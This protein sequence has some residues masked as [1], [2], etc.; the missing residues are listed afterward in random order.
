MF[1]ADKNA[2]FSRLVEMLQFESTFEPAFSLVGA[3]LETNKNLIEEFLRVEPKVTDQIRAELAK[4]PQ[5]SFF[6][7]LTCPYLNEQVSIL[8]EKKKEPAATVGLIIQQIIRNLV[9]EI[10]IA[11]PAFQSSLSPNWTASGDIVLDS[12]LAER[13]PALKT[14]GGVSLNYQ[15]YAHNTGEPGIGG[16]S[17]QDAL[18]HKERIETAQAIVAKVSPSALSMVECFT[19]VIQFRQNTERPNVVNSSRHTSIGL[20][21]CD[22]FHK[23]HDDMPEV[24]DMLVHESIHQ[25]LHLFEEQLFAFVDV[26]KAPT[27][28][29]DERLYPSPWSGNLLDLRS[30]TH[31]ILV[32]YGLANFWEQF[33]LGRFEHPEVSNEL[34][35]QKLDEACLGFLKCD[36]VLAPLSSVQGSLVPE[37]C[38]EILRIQ[39]EIKERFA[40]L[41]PVA[42]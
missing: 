3:H 35:K 34:A 27:E 16:Y 24:V 6:R 22:N 18:K 40:K 29:L 23:L 19:T 42:V 41:E 14:V 21:R 15:S 12:R 30:F 37:Y 36:S 5:E 11:N 17:Y 13:F 20:I 32:W 39:N 26:T 4:L 33:Y 38:K 9:A 25:F 1:T 2:D 8:K 31:A 28:T 7:L 10:K